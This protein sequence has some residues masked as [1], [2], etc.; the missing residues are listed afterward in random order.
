AGEL[1]PPVGAVVEQAPASPPFHGGGRRTGG[2]AEVSGE[3]ARVGAFA[4]LGQPEDGLERLA[5]CLGQGS[6]HGL[7]GPQP[8]F[9]GPKNATSAR[10]QACRDYSWTARRR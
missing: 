8:T 5:L 10:A 4:V 7:G 3:L 2:N 1:D 6:I 9:W